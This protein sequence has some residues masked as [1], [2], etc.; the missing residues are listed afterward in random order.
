VNNQ[1]LKTALVWATIVVGLLLVVSYFGRQTPG[2]TS[3]TYS[4]F[5]ADVRA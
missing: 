5:L 4:R 2:V 1:M 3:L